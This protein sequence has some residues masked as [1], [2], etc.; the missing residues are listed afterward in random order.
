MSSSPPEKKKILYKFESF[1]F[2]SIRIYLGVS[3]IKSHNMTKH[4]RM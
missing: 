2:H 1:Y 4:L 3:Y